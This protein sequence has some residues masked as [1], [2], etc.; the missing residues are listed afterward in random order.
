MLER[1]WAA[2]RES[3]AEVPPCRHGEKPRFEVEWYSAG[4]H[5]TFDDKLPGRWS[6]SYACV[7]PVEC[8]RAAIAGFSSPRA[9]NLL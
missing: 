5:G 7:T 6:F 4:L 9:G 8:E 2:V 3:Q 1:A